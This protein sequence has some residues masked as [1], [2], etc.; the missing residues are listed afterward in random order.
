MKWITLLK[1]M[2]VSIKEKNNLEVW[3]ITAEKFAWLSVVVWGTE[4]TFDQKTMINIMTEC[5]NQFMKTWF[6]IDIRDID[7]IQWF[8]KTSIAKWIDKKMF[9]S[10]VYKNDDIK[11]WKIEGDCYV[12][13]K[14]WYKL[15][16]DKKTLEFIKYDEI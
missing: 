13:E 14:N 15:F 11:K 2:V 12:I 1:W 10:V 5:G 7:Y 6:L 16:Y 3:W 8:Y 4:K 9:T